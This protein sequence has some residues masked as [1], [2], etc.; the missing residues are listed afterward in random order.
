[1]DSNPDATLCKANFL[2]RTGMQLTLSVQES[3]ACSHIKECH[4]VEE[5]PK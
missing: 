4:T 1:M 5:R 3:S 2:V